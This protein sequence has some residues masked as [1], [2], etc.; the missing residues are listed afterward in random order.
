[1]RG[2]AFAAM[3]DFHVTHFAVARLARR[4]VSKSGFTLPVITAVATHYR[5]FDE[6]FCRIPTSD[7]PAEEA[8]PRCAALRGNHLLPTDRR[9]ID[10][11]E[12]YG[13]ATS[14][15]NSSD[16]GKSQST[17]VVIVVVSRRN[18]PGAFV[19]NGF[20]GSRGCG[21]GPTLYT[22]RRVRSHL[23]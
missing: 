11:F 2:V 20:G 23:N 19:D 4:L 12:V 10:L 8:S 21:G 13:G 3:T 15:Q 17:S 5:L 6:L 18:R 7:G 16:D 1:M 14:D 22:A 9:G